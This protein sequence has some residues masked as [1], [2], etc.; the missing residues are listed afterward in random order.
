MRTDAEIDHGTAAVYSGRG[1]IRDLRFNDLPL[2]LVVLYQMLDTGNI[3]SIEPDT[4]QTSRVE[5]L[6]VRPDVPEDYK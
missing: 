5:S 1:V 4:P 6:L 2:V 3:M